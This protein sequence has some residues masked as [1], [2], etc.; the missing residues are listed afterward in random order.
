MKSLLTILALA[1]IAV[2]PAAFAND[3]S[4]ADKMDKD[5][6]KLDVIVFYSDTCGSCKILEPKMM[7]AM[8]VLNND[9]FNVVKFDF[10]NKQTIET[11]R[12]LAKDND[13]DATLQEY[14]AKTGF[15][16]LLDN[17]GNEIEKLT[18]KDSA[19]DIAAKLT[20][21]VLSLDDN[22]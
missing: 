13:V 14:G 5:V 15:V 21:S 10:S 19:A 6:K 22:A 16:V 7:D 3:H 20:S 9:S 11:T 2:M 18:V 17:D 4:M 8:A 12:K 1:L